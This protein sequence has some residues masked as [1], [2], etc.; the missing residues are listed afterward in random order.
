MDYNEILQKAGFSKDQ[1]LIYSSLIKNGPAPARKISLNT[2]IKRGLLYKVLDQLNELGLI[3]KIEKEGSVAIFKPK[4][5]S[6]I[7]EKLE[8]KKKDL[9]IASQS[10]KVVVGQMIS[11]FNLISGKPNVQYFE[12]LEGV[13]LDTEFNR[14][15]LKNYAKDVT[16]A[17]LLKMD[18]APFAT[19]MQ[20]YDGKVSYI[21][22]DDDG[23]S[24][25]SMI[26]TNPHIYEMHKKLFEVNWTQSIPMER[27]LNSAL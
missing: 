20:I 21:T 8:Q 15:F 23:K 12:G 24:I 25:I 7:V 17:R 1:S 26:I 3:E 10:L 16:D 14:N 27:T 11:D 9:Q 19:I 5:P 13:V 22:F 4:H 18:T 2:N 6:D